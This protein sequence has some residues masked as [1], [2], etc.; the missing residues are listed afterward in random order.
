MGRQTSNRPGLGSYPAE[1]LSIQVGKPCRYPIHTGIDA[2][3][4]FCTAVQVQCPLL[5]RGNC[6]QQ[7]QDIAPH[8]TTASALFGWCGLLI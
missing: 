1:R 5:T 4:L 7:N 3:V 8:H 2:P 6:L